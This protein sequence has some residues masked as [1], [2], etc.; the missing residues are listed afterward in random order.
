LLARL[1]LSLYLQIRREVWR[2]LKI[3]QG[4]STSN[5]TSIQV[6]KKKKQQQQQ[7]QLGHFVALVV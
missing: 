7:Q 3:S 6:K 4:F 5:V 1:L 2:S